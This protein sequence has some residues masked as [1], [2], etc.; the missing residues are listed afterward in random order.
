M[1]VRTC[2]CL[3]VYAPMRACERACVLVSMRACVRASNPH[4]QPCTHERTNVNARMPT[5]THTHSLTHTH[6]HRRVWRIAG[7]SQRRSLLLR[8][9]C[10]VSSASLDSS[11][12]TSG[13]QA[14]ASL[15]S[16]QLTMT[17]GISFHEV[18]NVGSAKRE[19]F[20]RD[21]ADDL[22][23]ASGLPAENFKITKL[24]AGSVIVDIDIMPDPLGIASD[25]STIARDLEKQVADPNSPLRLGKLT[26][27]TKGIQVLCPQPF[28]P[29]QAR[30]QASPQASRSRIC[31]EAKKGMPQVCAVC[32]YVHALFHLSFV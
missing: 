27:Q 21:V 1:H 28:Y 7:L 30:T 31:P 12:S 5:H 19:A 18:G 10:D 4:V 24:S 11:Q 6:T 16:V 2:V 15:A 14:S 9:K 29:L 20:K 23:K 8:D 22:A 25:P 32:V 13:D 26:R 17:L 3:C